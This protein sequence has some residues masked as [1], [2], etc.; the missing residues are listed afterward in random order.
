M[1]GKPPPRSSP[2]SA[3]TAACE[4]ALPVKYCERLWAPILPVPRFTRL[5]RAC[6]GKNR[7]QPSAILVVSRIRPNRISG[8]TIVEVMM[9]SVILVVGFLGMIQG[10]TVGSEMM[11]TARR[12][13]LAAQIINH[14]TDRLRLEAWST[15]SGLSTST[16]W[17]SATAYTVGTV[18]TYQGGSFIC[19][20][21]NTNQTPGVS[22][23]WSAYMTYV[24]TTAYSKSDI[25]SYNGT[26][27]RCIAATTGNLPTNTSYWS[28]YSGPAGTTGV[29]LGT[30]F[31]LTR[32]TTDIDTDAD[33]VTDLKEVT[34]VVTWTKSGTTTAATA[35][36][37]SWFN[38]L[39]F[40]GS[41]PI[42]R[43]YVRKS[44]TYFGKYGLNLAYQR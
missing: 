1:S 27:Y 28:A 4:P 30:T 18:V 36:S 17:S 2:P 22:N 35:A 11:A 43:T 9:A 25:V 44:T 8:F 26:W 14:E 10:I 37:G 34:F 15:I 40:S 12:Q 38:V 16:A 20:T 13:A 5:Q 19:V 42:S 6:A 23:S 3:G 39:S 31:T 33:S 24:A 21:A 29:S 7:L 32:I 41:A